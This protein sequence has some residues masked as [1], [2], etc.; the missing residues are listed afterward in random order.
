MV[1]ATTIACSFLGQLTNLFGMDHEFEIDPIVTKYVREEP[2]TA[3]EAI[4]LQ[5]WIAA[6]SGRAELLEQL[7][8]DPEWTKTNL[9]RIQDLPHTRVWENLESRLNAEGVWTAFDDEIRSAAPVVPM[10]RAPGGSG[11]WRYA[12]AACLIVAVASITYL[13]RSHPPTPAAV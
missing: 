4:A 5:Q 8:N 2:L 1:N 13:F 9:I 10:H 6:G 3:E 11:W 12:V 7:R